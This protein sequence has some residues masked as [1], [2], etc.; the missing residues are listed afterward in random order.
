MNQYSVCDVKR[1]VERRNRLK[2]DLCGFKFDLDRNLRDFHENLSKTKF[3]FSVCTWLVSIIF[4]IQNFSE[5]LRT[6]LGRPQN[7]PTFSELL[8]EILNENMRKI[9]N[10]TISMYRPVYSLVYFSSKNY[11]DL[12]LNRFPDLIPES[13]PP[14]QRLSNKNIHKT[15]WDVPVHTVVR[16]K[17]GGDEKK[18]AYFLKFLSFSETIPNRY[19]DLIHS[20]LD[21]WRRSKAL[22]RRKRPSARNAPKTSRYW[23]L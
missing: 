12:D 18:Y 20:F 14:C 3:T 9:Q 8:R 16:S 13:A 10:L 5:L 11:S 17:A 23:G 21:V 2:I 6:S 1:A 22:C 19:M 15:M 7:V 4:W